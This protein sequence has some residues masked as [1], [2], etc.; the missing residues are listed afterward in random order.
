[1][2]R[3]ENNKIPSSTKNQKTLSQKTKKEDK[4]FKMPL[5]KIF[6]DEIKGN[7][8]KKLHLM[9]NQKSYSN[10]AQSKNELS[11]FNLK[12][13]LFVNKLLEQKYNCTPDL[14]EKNKLDILVSKKKCHYLANFNEIGYCTTILTEYLKREYSLKEVYTRIPQ[15]ASYYKN[16]LQ[17]FCKP[18]FTHYTINKKMVRHMEKVAQ[19]FY[20]E[21]Y[22]DDDEN[23]EKDQ[24]Q[25]KK[26]M[27]KI[28]SKDVMTDIENGDSFT[29]VNSEAAMEQ[30]QLINKKLKKNENLNSKVKKNEKENYNVLPIVIEQSTII[31]NEQK[32]TPIYEKDE[33]QQK[34]KNKT[35]IVFDLDN[36]DKSNK[37]ISNLKI[38]QSTSSI[39]MLL[40]EMSK[41]KK[42]TLFLKNV[43]DINENPFTFRKINAFISPS[44]KPNI[45]LA[46]SKSIKNLNNNCILIQNGK[47]TNNINININNL[48]IG[49]KVL[50]KNGSF[51]KIIN[52]LRELN[53]VNNNINNENILKKTITK[54]KYKDS[55]NNS[56]LKIKDRNSKK[57][58]INIKSNTES[59][60]NSNKIQNVQSKTKLKKNGLL[61][62]PPHAINILPNFQSNHTKKYSKI[63]PSTLA[64]QVKKTRNQAVF[65]FGHISGSTTNIY[66]HKKLSY[67]SNDQNKYGRFTIHGN[68]QINSKNI[69]N[70][71]DLL[72]GQR[73]KNA[74]NDIRRPKKIFTSILHLNKG[75]GGEP[76]FFNL[77]NKLDTYRNSENGIISPANIKKKDILINKMKIKELKLKEKQLNYHK[78]LNLM[79]RNTRSKSTNN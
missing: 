48:T 73:T 65:K 42:E 72:S 36:M 33:F 49:Q 5:Y 2:N 54:F 22:A 8:T 23:K 19:I 17:F 63:V 20:N 78:M 14:Y 40:K 77:K 38:S 3:N 57:N 24:S 39:K 61:T 79:P 76:H 41:D 60:P 52:N 74:S 59:A 28:F 21:N 58:L 68:D 11:S 45:N 30:I 37:E 53:N 56:I 18:F 12:L 64:Y 75:G 32:I 34:L 1:M 26:K 69:L 70:N 15:Y 66:K 16:Y 47:T 7:S 50:S 27:P 13:E 46:K 10:K 25:N 44:N 6:M 55:N 51:N 43:K 31:E 62:L 29:Y 67:P 9:K 71:N 4:N 35:K